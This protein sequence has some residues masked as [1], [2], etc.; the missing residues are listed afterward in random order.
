MQ[1]TESTAP[2]DQSGRQDA[3]APTP[4]VE[5]AVR[6]R[7]EWARQAVPELAIA[8]R[9]R[10]DAVLRH[11]AEAL[12]ANTAAIL[13][14][15]RE[16]RGRGR[17][18]GTSAAMLDRLKLDEARVEALALALETLAGLPDPVGTVVRGGPLPNGVRMSQVRVPLGVVGAVYEA[19]PNVTVDIAGIALKSGNGVILR[20]GSAA[21]ST[22]AVLI[23]VLREALVDQ[24]FDPN[25]IQGIDD[26]G[27]PGV[28]A[29]MAARGAVD[30]LVPRG[31]RELIQRV[32]REARV[33]VIE[34][35]E[36]NVHLYVDASAPKQMAVDI[37]LNAKTHR[38][39]VC[40]AAE[41]LLLHRD[42]EE[43]GR[44]VL[45]ALTRAGVLLHVDEAARA[46]L[47]TLADRGDH[48]RDAVDA[49]EEDWGTEYLDM[50]MAVRVV[51]SLDQAIEHIGRWS[52]GHTEAIVTNDL[53]AAERFIT[54]VDAAAVIVNA[55]TRFTD[56][57]ELGLGAEVGISTQKMHARGPMGLEEL[58]TTK[59]ILRGD[60]QI[61][62]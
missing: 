29:L 54:E 20:G 21:E 59:W 4:E 1:T 56:G 35:G 47:P 3:E 6:Q 50:E 46:W 16:D 30:V 18:T 38:T 24:G 10:K 5:E 13:T 49:T 57:G 45:R 44:E 51:D 58:T 28:A 39:S 60:G 27:R 26:L 2:Q 53:A 40:N 19:R 32:V 22:N 7:A 12:R 11:M 62:R 25:I 37:A 17:E 43:T 34:T 9:A 52:T 42:A 48:A 14:A 41:T 36:G 61:R 15:N 23:Q 55:S 31:G 8:G 33:P